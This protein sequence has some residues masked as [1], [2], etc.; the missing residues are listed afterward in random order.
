MAYSCGVWRLQPARFL[1]LYFSLCRT[2]ITLLSTRAR[3]I[4]GSIITT[5]IFE[6]MN[7]EAIFQSIDRKHAASQYA[8][9]PPVP[10]FLKHNSN[11]SSLSFA[12]LSA[13]C[14]SNYCTMPHFPSEFSNTRCNGTRPHLHCASVL[15]SA[16]IRE[17]STS[18]LDIVG[19]KD[20]LDK[21]LRQCHGRVGPPHFEASVYGRK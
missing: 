15:G 8:G 20:V 21:N 17:K 4:R 13:L 10:A 16:S 2:S 12:S 1:K 11:M 7:S 9:V 14:F 19:S 3:S 18:S 5:I 6:K